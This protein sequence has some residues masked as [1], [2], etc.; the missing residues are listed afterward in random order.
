[1]ACAF[2]THSQTL[3][4]MLAL[5]RFVV[6]VSMAVLTSLASAG[7]LPLIAKAEIEA[8]LTALKSSACQFNRNGTWYSGADAQAHLAKKLAYLADRHQ[9]ASAE[10]F[11]EKAASASS[12]SG[13]RYQVRCGK[14]P[15]VDSKLWLQDQLKALRAAKP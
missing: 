5:S 8:M 13:K 10:E 14:T 11:I 1:V 9:I 2:A 12:I 4:H 15:A 7:E 3:R 6:A